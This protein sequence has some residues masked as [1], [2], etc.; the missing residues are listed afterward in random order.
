MPVPTIRGGR[1]TLGVRNRLGVRSAA[2]LR[3]EVHQHKQLGVTYAGF[4]NF[5]YTGI[6]PPTTVSTC[7]GTV[8]IDLTAQ[9]CPVRV[10]SQPTRGGVWAGV[11]LNIQVVFVVGCM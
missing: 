3:S 5:S 10:V 8:H 7:A 11:G 4:V 6:L 1:R 9:T 2:E